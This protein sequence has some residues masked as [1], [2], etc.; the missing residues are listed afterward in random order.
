MTSNDTYHARRSKFINAQNY[1]ELRVFLN[2]VALEHK[3][4]FHFTTMNALAQ[5]VKT[6]KWR[7]S[8]AKKTNDLQELNEKG[9]KEKWKRIFAAS[10]SHGDEDNMGMWKMYGCQEPDNQICIGFKS[11]AIKKWINAINFID[12]NGHR[13]ASNKRDTEYARDSQTALIN[14]HDIIYAHGFQNTPEM[15][16]CWGNIIKDPT[17]FNGD[18]S[19]QP[20]LTGYIKN[21]AW[22]YEKE[23]R[24]MVVLPPA[25]LNQFPN[26]PDYIFISFPFDDL[27]G[28]M[29]FRFSPFSH[30]SE[31]VLKE[32]LKKE[33]RDAK[34]DP[35]II[36][37]ILSICRCSDFYGKINC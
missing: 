29:S 15:R 9:Y 7:L 24:L 34:T 25:I 8:S 36:E 35:S 2:S 32:N 30:T 5:I 12:V 23:T 4:F 3:L 1:E 10:F 11:R 13:L 16:I 31:L 14:F 22:E 17:K 21:S 27:I 18:P 20:L 37:K 19:Q 26:N 28:G 33:L 6:G